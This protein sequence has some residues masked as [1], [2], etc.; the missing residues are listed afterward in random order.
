M[1]KK[2]N[3][4]EVAIQKK[5]EVH[6]KTYKE[7]LEKRRVLGIRRKLRRK[8]PR[9]KES[10][11][12]TGPQVSIVIKGD[13]DGSLEAILDVLET[14]D[15]KQCR[16]D[17]IHYGVGALTESDVNLAEPFNGMQL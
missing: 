13:V 1:E 8:G 3:E 10:V 5:I 15:S 9:P 14:Y 7:E 4:D 11:E 2:M 12:V 16:L 17:I 6:L